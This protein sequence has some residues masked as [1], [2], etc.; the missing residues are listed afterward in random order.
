VYRAA[1]VDNRFVPASRGV[2]PETRKTVAKRTAGRC[3]E[4]DN[5]LMDIGSNGVRL[6]VVQAPASVMASAHS[7][8]RGVEKRVRDGRCD[9]MIGVSPAPPRAGPVGSAGDIERRT[10]ANRGPVTEEG[11][12]ENA[13]FSNRIS[14]RRAATP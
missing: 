14:S 7:L 6:M 2:E 12:I 8:A 3:R 5:G 4:I 13:A 1:G 11:R 9:R 10:S